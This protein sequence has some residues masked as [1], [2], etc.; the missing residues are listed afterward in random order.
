MTNATWSL[1]R[2]KIQLQMFGNKGQ[3]LRDQ[4]CGQVSFYLTS[5]TRLL[6]LVLHWLEAHSPRARCA[7]IWSQ[8]QLTAC[9][10]MHCKCLYMVTERSTPHIQAAMNEKYDFLATGCITARNGFKQPLP[11]VL[12]LIFWHTCP[13]SSFLDSSLTRGPNSPWCR[14]LRTKLSIVRTCKAWWQINWKFLYEVC[15]VSAPPVISPQDTHMKFRRS[16]FVA[17]INYQPL[18][19]PLRL[20]GLSSAPLS[21]VS[22]STVFYARLLATSS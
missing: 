6:K 19:A 9:T 16:S 5:S 12:H 15:F 7:Y 21:K 10:N 4:F 11:E 17:L 8:K 22:Q 3:L 1:D 13:P 14:S 18:F 2:L 20:P